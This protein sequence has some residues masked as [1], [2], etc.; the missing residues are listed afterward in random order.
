MSANWELVRFELSYLRPLPTTMT[1]TLCGPKV[2]TVPVGAVEPPD[3]PTAPDAV[4]ATVA[5]RVLSVTALLRARVQVLIL[6]STL[7]REVI[8]GILAVY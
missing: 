1:S 6:A 8:S 3:A 5:S 4:A 2:A 7:R